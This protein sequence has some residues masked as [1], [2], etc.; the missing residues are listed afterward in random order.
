MLRDFKYEYISDTDKQFLM[1]VAKEYLNKERFYDFEIR[2]RS[3]IGGLVKPSQIIITSM[4]YKF[5]L[6][7]ME[8]RN[9]W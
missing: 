8:F 2:M 9:K 1:R 7:E 3:N 6:M 4:S 5:D